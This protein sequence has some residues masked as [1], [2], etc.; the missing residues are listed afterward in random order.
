MAFCE[1]S[2]A[3]AST[4]TLSEML[5]LADVL[6]LSLSSELSVNGCRL[7]GKLKIHRARRGMG[8]EL[9]VMMWQ[10]LQ[11]MTEEAWSLWVQKKQG[12]RS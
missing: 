10:E 12:S 11:V 6:K 8:L 9:Q 5:E 4:W 7:K 3:E 1:A 2:G